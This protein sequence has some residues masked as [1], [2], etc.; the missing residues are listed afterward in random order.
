MPFSA[1]LINLEKTTDN[2]EVIR[3]FAEFINQSLTHVMAALIC[4]YLEF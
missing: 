1:A 2:S 3:A 4:P